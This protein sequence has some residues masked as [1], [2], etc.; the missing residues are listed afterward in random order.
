MVVSKSIYTLVVAFGSCTWI[1]TNSVWMQL[2]LFTSELP[3]GWSLPSYLSVVVQIACI[4]PLIYTIVHKGCKTVEIPHIR[5]IFLFLLLACA[6]QLGL[7][8]LWKDTVAIGSKRYSLALYLL[9][10]GLA[11]V[12]AMSNVLFMP[13][14]ANFHPS[15]LNAY[16]VGMG[17]SSL[18]P[19]IL[20]LIQGSSNYVCDG[21]VPHYT[22]PR[23]S[24]AIFFLVIFF[25]TLVS[26]VAF[27]ALYIVAIK[28]K[29]PSQQ[30]DSSP[31]VSM[32]TAETEMSSEQEILQRSKALPG[33]SYLFILLAVSLVNAQMN[34]IIPSISSF[35][36]LPYS[37][38]TYHYSIALSNVI[39]PMA[40]FLSFFVMVRKLHFLGVLSGMS[41]CATIFLI[42]LAAL[43]PAMIFDS[44]S[45]GAALSIL[46]SL[47]AAGLHSYLRVAFASRFRECDQSESRL[48]WCGVF[49]QIGSFIGSMVMLIVNLNHVFKS[50][51]PC[52]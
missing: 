23:F 16:F 19:S 5:L 26:T 14:M 52:R 22:P 38:A 21:D 30:G 11:V 47:T 31:E 28:R 9:L 49:T 3:E 20:A 48:F 24:A 7:V 8:F 45:G 39:M 50:A 25:S 2:S 4:G 40:S 44:K 32:D 34:G 18:I 35:S 27:L 6:C 51:P 33:R 17:F 29:N 36:S 37:Q 1:G 46:A 43:S 12:D 13:F 15:Y 41:T 42:Y 10:F